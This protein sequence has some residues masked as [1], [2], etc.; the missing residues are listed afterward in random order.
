MTNGPFTHSNLLHKTIDATLAIYNW[1]GG[2][3][4]RAVEGGEE[5]LKDS[6]VMRRQ[7]RVA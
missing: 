5:M 6:L 3:E 7:F 4:F 2:D 1:A